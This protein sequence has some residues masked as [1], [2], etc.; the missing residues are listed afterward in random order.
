MA[1]SQ[2]AYGVEKIIGNTED[3]TII[4]DI[5][6]YEN[7]NFGDK[8]EAKMKALTWQGKNSVKLGM[9]SWI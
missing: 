2:A 9:F 5:T 3:A 7:K 8:S 4:T 1:V 6:N